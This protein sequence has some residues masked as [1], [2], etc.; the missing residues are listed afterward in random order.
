MNQTLNPTAELT[1][2]DRCDKCGAQAFHRAVLVAGE[3][4]FCSHHAR[5]YASTLSQ[6]AL[7]ID[8]GS[9]RINSRPSPAAY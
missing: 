5:K 1:A 2:H 9:A 3:L 4:L 6:V 7:R 8:D